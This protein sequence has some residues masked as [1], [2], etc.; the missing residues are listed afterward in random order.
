MMRRIAGCS[1]LGQAATTA[2]RTLALAAAVFVLSA[3]QASARDGGERTVRVRVIDSSGRAVPDA[4]AQLGSGA[5]RV[6]N[7]SGRVEFSAADGDSVRVLVPRIGFIPFQSWLTYA[8]DGGL[9][10]IVSPLPQNLGRVDILA[11]PPWRF[12]ASTIAWTA[13]GLA[14]CRHGS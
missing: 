10:A 12:A 6:A 11:P 3:T 9:T 14:P 2:L 7:D 4:Q 5:A 8:V 1:A 13:R